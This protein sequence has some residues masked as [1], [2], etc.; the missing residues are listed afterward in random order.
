MNKK[1]K[2]PGDHECKWFPVCP[3][4]WFYEA[5]RLDGKWVEQYC[6]GDWKSCVRYEMEETGRYHPDWMLPDGSIDE[7][8]KDQ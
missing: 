1:H 2:M 4:K 3:M 8:L 5:R 6:R 7:S